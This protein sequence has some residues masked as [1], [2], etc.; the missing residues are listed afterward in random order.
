[1]KLSVLKY[2]ILILCLA[3]QTI[4]AYA[5]KP[6]VDTIESQAGK[7]A[8]TDE[9]YFDA[10]KA[11]IH[12]D[13]KLAKQLL[14][15][16]AAKRPEVSG[17]FYELARLY[18]N[19]KKLDTAE[20]YI[21]KA[22]ALS[23]DNKWYQEE[24]ASILS[25]QGK[26]E[27]AANVVAELFTKEPRDR[28]YPLI[29]A[30]YYE[31]AKKYEDALQYLDKAIVQIGPD[32]DILTKK[33]QVYLQMNN[34]GKAA[35]MIQQLIQQQPKNGKYYKLL[36][37]LYDN[38]R[39]PAKAAEVYTK[40]Q[41]ALPGDPI[42]ELGLAEHYLTMGD[43]TSYMAHVK[44]AIINK[45]LD[46]DIQLQILSAYIQSLPNDSI[47]KAQGLPIIN[48]LIVQHPDDPQVMELYAG[49]MEINNQH[50]SAVLAY[51]KSL[52]IKPSNFKVWEKLL[53]SYTDRKDADSLV[54]YSERAMR[55]F[56][57]QAAAHYYNS[58]A[59]YNKKEYPTAV[60]AMNRA[61]EN[62]P[63]NNKEMLAIFYGFLGDIYH[64]NKQDDLSD[65]AY[66]QSLKLN[67]KDAS[68]LNNYSYYL[69]ER[70]TKL[71]EAE[72]MSKKSLE[73]KPTEAT[74][75]DTYGWILYQKGSY[76]KAKEYIQKAIDLSGI[77]ADATLYEHL[78]NIYYKLNDKGKAVE[79]W[80]MSKE[81]GGSG[82]LIDKK[83]REG[84]LYE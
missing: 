2:P 69:S 43:T 62:E 33:M 79:Y 49:F 15:Q 58:I 31:R 35:A 8:K 65:Q 70:N 66:E 56:P 3:G 14:T 57:N 84:K 73:L 82:P 60:K 1:M 68:V 19:E 4:S 41:K 18:D 52:A 36:G 51:K 32:E 22:I 6:P 7:A 59:H 74:F 42:I 44:K 72:K 12:D 67:P 50:D 23:P 10:I 76:D 53:R 77:N 64:L 83:I 80:K 45:D 13:N 61:I 16:Y 54:K 21:K 63:E 71:D 39:M 47:L 24:Y 81:K 25:D 46:A 55:L 9:L 34:V 30:E 75:L 48:Q 78:G 27:D 5:Q 38:N 11:K 37:D 29:A 28:S 17:A 40:A 20:K 26:Y